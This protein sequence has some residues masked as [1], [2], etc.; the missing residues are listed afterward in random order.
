[1]GIRGLGGR[2]LEGFLVVGM[3][4]LVQA[5]V[6][7]GT[8]GKATNIAV[9]GGIRMAY[10]YL[11]LAWTRNGEILAIACTG[12]PLDPIRYC[13]LMVRKDDGDDANCLLDEFR[14]TTE[15]LTGFFPRHS[16]PEEMRIAGI[17]FA[18]REEPNGIYLLI[19]MTSGGGILQYWELCEQERPIH[20]LF[21]SGG[22]VTSRTLQWQCQSAFNTNSPVSLLCPTR[23]TWAVANDSAAVQHHLIFAT[24][25]GDLICLQRE[26]MQLIGQMNVTEKAHY[27]APPNKAVSTMSFT[28]TGNALIVFD[29]AAT[30]FVCKLSPVTDPGGPI[31]IPYAVMALEY[32]L[33]TGIDH[34]D[35]LIG[36]RPAMLDSI[37]E[38]LTENFNQQ[39]PGLQQLL[40]Y[41]LLTTK[42]A[43]FRLVPNGNAKAGLQY[44]VLMLTSVYSALRSMLRPPPELFNQERAPAD[45]LT[46][47]LSS[48][49]PEGMT[50]VD[51]VLQIHL[52]V[53]EFTVEPS[54]LI[55]V[56]HLIRW[57]ATFILKLLVNLPEWRSSP[58]RGNMSDFFR[59]A[60]LI[61]MLRELLVIFRIWGLIRQSCLPAFCYMENID[62][63]A[64][65]FR[66]L[67]RLLQTP[68]PDDA[69]LDECSQLSSQL[70]I[71]ELGL[72]LPARGL[73]SPALF[74]S[75]WPLQYEYGVQAE[76]PVS[77]K[78]D[79]SLTSGAVAS[80]A[81]GG[82]GVGS[83]WENEL[84][85]DSV[86]HVYLG[87][88]PHNVRYCSRCRGVSII[89]GLARST[90]AKSWDMRW[91]MACP[92]RG[93]WSRQEI[94]T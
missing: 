15:A 55:T 46:A 40:H 8:K 27:E 94:D 91:Q 45:S 33:T 29:S 53:K 74:L 42:M 14:V 22:S 16:T 60:K 71:P 67:T 50:E 48:K 59:D 88:K 31:T 41:R 17:N 89:K 63:I 43:I 12:N 20:S 64:T 7:G 1:M 65:L 5:F 6:M 44:S 4:G 85:I 26:N 83:C 34:W 30:M 84:K 18:C 2:S 69:L 66:I 49:V 24:R 35:I 54:T 13:K 77:L 58:Q 23:H 87:S 3:T 28:A 92:C 61:N 86:R 81:G 75:Q 19:N 37:C 68:E 62:V 47:V 39:S 70:V 82:T 90:A 11:D 10:Q 36:L 78:F 9:L 72:C 51:K 73:A 57:T 79:A 56:Q 21:S 52:E 32:C 38:R 80:G 25:S 93:A 76:E